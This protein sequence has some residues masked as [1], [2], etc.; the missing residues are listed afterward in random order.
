MN[1]QN[2]I[3]FNKLPESK[4]REIQLKGSKES[5]RIRRERMEQA[6]RDKELAGR[7]VNILDMEI[8][9]GKLKND[10]VKALGVKKPTY[11]DA[12]LYGAVRKSIQGNAQMFNSII[13]AIEQKPTPKSQVEVTGL[14]FAGIDINVKK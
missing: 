3:P 12:M 7:L 14:P 6:A 5:A 8:P 4:Q 1:D 11:Q 9:D 2:L 13:E 10:I